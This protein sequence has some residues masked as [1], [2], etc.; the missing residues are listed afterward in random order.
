METMP[1]GGDSPERAAIA[2]DFRKRLWGAV[3]ARILD[4]RERKVVYCLFELDLKPK[5][6]AE[7]YPEDFC[8]VHEVY[9]VRQIVLERLGRDPNIRK[10]FRSDA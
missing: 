7:R 6:I 5:A 8:D 9:R 10:L 1:A 2:G 3:D 4:E